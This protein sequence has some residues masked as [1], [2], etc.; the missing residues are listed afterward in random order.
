MLLPSQSLP[1]RVAHPMPLPHFM[2]ER[3]I[4]TGN[5]LLWGI[6]YLQI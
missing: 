2:S 3:V 6:K 5:P 1:P 4:P